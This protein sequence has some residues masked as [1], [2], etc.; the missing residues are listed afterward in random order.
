MEDKY[1][2]VNAV[3]NNFTNLC[4]KIDKKKNKYI[5]DTKKIYQL[6]N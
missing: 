6:L 5:Y 4:I 3:F 2:K 1:N